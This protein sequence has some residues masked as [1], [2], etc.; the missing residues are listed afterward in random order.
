MS[1]WPALRV[2]VARLRKFDALASGERGRDVDHV[3]LSET[4]RASDMSITTAQIPD[5]A[6]I[7]VEG[8]I[9]PTVAGLEFRGTVR[10]RGPLNAAAVSSMSKARSMR[11]F[12]PS[13]SRTQTSAR[14]LR[15]TCIRS[16]ATTSMS[17]MS[18]SRS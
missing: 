2:N 7:G 11:L 12:M 9:T 8:T 6:D 1:R 17:V 10:S 15:P 3:V 16:M 14:T 5:G 13:S 4:V 18:S